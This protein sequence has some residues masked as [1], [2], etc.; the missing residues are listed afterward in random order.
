MESKCIKTWRII[1]TLFYFIIACLIVIIWKD[2]IFYMK[3]IDDSYNWYRFLWCLCS[4]FLGFSVLSFHV[5][6]HKNSPFP[7]FITYYPFLLFV[8]SALVFSVCH[9]FDK[10]SGFIYY[11]LSFPICFILGYLVDSF[12][13]IITSI[14]KNKT[15]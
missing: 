3:I 1:F 13:G 12:W 4:S 8:I 9:L 7:S 10:S 2:K 15:K 11:Y 6:N 5:R 14:I